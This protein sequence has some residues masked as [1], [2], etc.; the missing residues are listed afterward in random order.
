MEVYLCICDIVAY[1]IRE[2]FENNLNVPLTR[3]QFK[4]VFIL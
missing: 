1:L 2:H 4:Y 3:E